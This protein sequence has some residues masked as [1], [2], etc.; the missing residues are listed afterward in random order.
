M[1]L[2]LLKLGFVESERG[3]RALRSPITFLIKSQSPPSLR[4]CGFGV[5]AQ[6]GA[7][8]RP[9]ALILAETDFFA[10]KDLNPVPNVPYVFFS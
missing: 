2:S 9:E 7:P 1:F 4:L 3:D 8:P 6:T 10:E 5:F